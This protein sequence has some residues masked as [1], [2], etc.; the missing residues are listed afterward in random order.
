MERKYIKKSQSIPA[1]FNALK[2]ICEELVSR[3][4]EITG[5]L[6]EWRRGGEEGRRK[7]PAKKR[8]PRGRPAIP[9]Q[10]ARDIHIQFT[11]EILDQVGIRPKGDPAGCWIV[12]EA[13]GMS[14]KQVERIW[15][16]CP[17][18]TSFLPMMRRYWKDIAKRHGLDHTR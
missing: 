10:F 13:L 15:K 6:D 14:E 2:R 11:I 9:A 7:P 4:E 18:R 5:P 1:Y 3:G 17:W 8:I 12:A 16:E